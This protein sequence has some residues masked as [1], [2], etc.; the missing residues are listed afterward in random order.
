MEI[1]LARMKVSPQTSS[2]L[3]CYASLTAKQRSQLL[4]ET[5]E[6][7][8]LDE[9]RLAAYLERYWPVHARPSQRE[10]GG[11]WRYWLI[12]AG[13]GYGK[14]RVGAEWV[15]A[16]ATAGTYRYVNVAGATADDARDIM[17]EG[18]S[19]ILAC[20]HPWERPEYRKHESKLIWPNGCQ[21]LI[22]TADKPDRFRGKQHE[23]LWA[24][25][26]AA[27]RYPE[28]WDQAM[29]GLRIGPDPRAVITTT[30]RPTRL[31]R[32]LVANPD[33]HTTRGST[34]ENKTNL[35][36]SF[37]ATIIRKYEGTTLGRQELDAE[38]LDSVEGALWTRALIDATRVDHAPPCRKK[39]VAV[40]PNVSSEEHANEAGIVVCGWDH[41]TLHG[42]VLEDATEVGGPDAWTRRAIRAYHEHSADRIVAEKN[43]GGELVRIAIHS[44]DPAVPV[45]LVTASQSKRTR[46]EP[47][48]M[49]YEQGRV[50][51]A[52]TFPDLEDQLVTWTPID[53]SP[54]RLDAMVWGLTE[55]MVDRSGVSQHQ[56][57]NDGRPGVRKTGDL[58][59]VGDRYVDEL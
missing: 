23:A 53:D 12:L 52:G 28:A 7:H 50:H 42:F 5:A 8:G 45:K 14:T 1:R 35:H 3:E 24:D 29:L 32:E 38:I 20:C 34:Y 56:Y 59:L 37:F 10:P 46:A 40:D 36:P 17:V 47:V 4:A 15:R 9:R 43:N 30:P 54:D 13:R 19:G 21:S 22:F 6:S 48:A 41:V 39:V 16:R 57:R 55:L 27:W 51:H 26:L 18:E 2:L 11:N 31:I 25:E 33:C 58:V 49:L 44:V